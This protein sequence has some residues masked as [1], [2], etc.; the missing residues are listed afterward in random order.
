MAVW[1]HERAPE[2][3]DGSYWCEPSR[4]EQGEVGGAKAS[5]HWRR[6]KQKISVMYAPRYAPIIAVGAHEKYR[7]GA[8]RRYVCVLFQFLRLLLLILLPRCGLAI[9]RSY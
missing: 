5:A 6:R 9:S 4:A 7:P 3:G 1:D 8:R 2:R